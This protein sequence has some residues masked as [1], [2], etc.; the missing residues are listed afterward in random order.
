MFKLLKEKNLSEAIALQTLIKLS[1]LPIMKNLRKNP[2]ELD[3]AR[4]S[5][6]NQILNPKQYGNRSLMQYWIYEALK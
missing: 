6:R 2:S 4:E 3:K 1:K 5:L